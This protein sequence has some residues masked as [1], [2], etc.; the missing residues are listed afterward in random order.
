MKLLITILFVFVFVLTGNSQKQINAKTNGNLNNKRFTY[1]DIS[2]P[3]APYQFAYDEQDSDDVDEFDTRCIIT[4]IVLKPLGWRAE[5]KQNFFHP[6]Y[7]IHSSKLLIDLP[8]PVFPL[9]F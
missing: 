8:P 6:F 4:I 2:I 9:T 7:Q 5:F 1:N 3:I